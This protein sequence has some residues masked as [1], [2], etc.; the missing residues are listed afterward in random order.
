MRVRIKELVESAGITRTRLCRKC[1]VTLRTLQRWDS[2]KMMP[3]MANIKILLKIFKCTPQDLF[4][5]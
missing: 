5:F 1:D 3:S 4:E 2:G